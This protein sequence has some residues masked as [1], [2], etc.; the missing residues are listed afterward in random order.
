MALKFRNPK[1]LKWCKKITA[2]LSIIPKV[3][4]ITRITQHI[5]YRGYEYSYGNKGNF[6][7]IGKSSV[8]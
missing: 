6:E 1:S 2:Q 8:G 4:T 7:I 5:E 3:K